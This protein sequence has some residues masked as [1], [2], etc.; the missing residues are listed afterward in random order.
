MTMHVQTATLTL[1]LV[2][3]AASTS[4]AEDSLAGAVTLYASF[5]THVRADRGGGSLKLSTRHDHPT[6]RGAY[7]FT[8]G[9]DS[10]KFRIAHG[11]GVAGGALE[12][13]DVLPRRGRM[14]FPADGNLAYDP[15]GWDGAVSFWLNTNPNSLLKTPFC[16]PVQITEKGAHNGGI[17]IDFPNTKPRDMRM[18]VFRGLAAG[19]KP[20]A[21]SDPQA[22]LVHFP[23]V[24]F[25]S[26]EWHHLALSW[27]NLD[28]GRPNTLAELYVDGRLV[29]Q[30]KERE[31]A[32]R[33]DLSRTGIYVAVNYIGLLDEL[34]VF[35]RALTAREVGILH[36]QP[37][38]AH[39]TSDK[40]P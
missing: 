16:D 6:E 21:E 9:F 4:A 8:D 30:L 5:D 38:W 7:V 35:K 24:P 15:R 1:F 23:R 32:M 10:A 28:T 31:I 14:F 13:L 19:E 12:C 27:R 2:L 29:G 36:R 33:W 3:L 17:W 25:Q 39:Q 22:P 40:L 37:D 26:G 18:G 34:V 20:L 11:K